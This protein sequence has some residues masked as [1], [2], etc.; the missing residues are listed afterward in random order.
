MPSLSKSSSTPVFLSGAGDMLRVFKEEPTGVSNLRCWV[1]IRGLLRP[2]LWESKLN[3]EQV[4]PIEN[5]GASLMSWNASQP[6]CQYSPR[7]SHTSRTTP[8]RSFW[9]K[10]WRSTSLAASV[11][12]H[13]W[14]DSS[15]PG[16]GWFNPYSHTMTSNYLGFA[17]R[18]S[19]NFKIFSVIGMWNFE[20]AFHS[21]GP[22]VEGHTI[23]Q[24]RNW[25]SKLLQNMYLKMWQG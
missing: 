18:N 4:P 25:L 10:R 19:K 20:P 5:G 22:N 13:A 17:C 11:G 8:V 1:S 24:T 2:S 14:I 12:R 15:G 6:L 3:V 16:A 23:P 21:W 9:T 7:V